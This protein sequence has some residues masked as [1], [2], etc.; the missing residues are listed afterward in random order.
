MEVPGRRGPGPGRQGSRGLTIDP[1]ATRVAV[2]GPGK[3]GSVFCR[4]GQTALSSLIVDVLAVRA[5]GGAHPD[6][7]SGADLDIGLSRT[8]LE[9]HGSHVP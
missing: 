6:V 1:D 7:A 4:T 9:G 8:L 3:D 5:R 2:Y